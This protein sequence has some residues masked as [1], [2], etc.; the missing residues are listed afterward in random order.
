M[1]ELEQPTMLFT[2]LM[3]VAMIGPLVFI[4]E[5]GHYLVGRYFNTKVDCFSIGFGRE[6]IGWN[7]KNG[8][9]WKIGWM[10]LGGYVKFTGDANAAGAGTNLS[11]VDPADRPFL[12]AFKPLWQRALI[13]AAGPAINFLAAIFIYSAFIAAYGQS[14]T[15]PAIT[16]VQ[17][18]SPA[19]AA[20]LVAGDVITSVD[21]QNVEK[22]EDIVGLVMINP[23]HPADITYTRA[24]ETL[25]ARLTPE[26]I[27]ERDRFGNRYTVPRLGI[28][29]GANAVIQRGPLESVYYGT[30]AVIKTTQFMIKGIVQIISGRRSV[31][32]LGGPLKIA[33]ISGKVATLGLEPFVNLMA[34]ISINLGFINLL[35]IPMLDGG[36]LALYAAEAVRRKPVS[37]QVQEWAFMTGFVLLISFMLFVTWNDLASFGVFKHV[38]GLIG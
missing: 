17:E 36:H 23:G 24:G 20:G 38:A 26:M 15:S 10:P 33:D 21:G 22:F 1:P 19:A 34:L 31:K 4:H 32:D 14:F 11:N 18:G 7:G 28:Y 35:P 12:F 30:E 25:H 5:L 37:A 29:G 13:V 3:F 8:T 9:R 27:E 6:I 2:A 16:G